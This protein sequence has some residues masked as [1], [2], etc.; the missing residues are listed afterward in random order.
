MADYWQHWLEVGDALSDEGRPQI[1]QVN[2]F[3][4]DAE[5]K[6]IWPG[7]ADNTR[8]VEWIINR[9]EG[10]ATG[11]ETAIGITPAPG[12]LNLEGVSVSAKALKELFAVNKSS[13]LD[14]ADLIS[15]YYE[16]FGAHVP[17]ALQDELESL[18]AR[19]LVSK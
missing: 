15:T 13:W 1:F 19:L 14:E 2:W 10:K 3:R 12:E 18:K 17:H 7:Y 6:Y 4:K 9:L 11:V 8:V 5:G 16:S